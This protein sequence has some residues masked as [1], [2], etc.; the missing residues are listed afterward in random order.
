LVFIYLIL[1]FNKTL[2]VDKIDIAN[3]NNTINIKSTGILFLLGKILK[4]SG[5][6][7]TD[8][9][10]DIDITRAITIVLDIIALNNVI[11]IIGKAA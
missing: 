10:L 4:T 1:C 9:L 3:D 7:K 8:K 2:I 11:L 5:V 6:K